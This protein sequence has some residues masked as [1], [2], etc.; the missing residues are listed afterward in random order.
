MEYKEGD[1]VLCTVERVSDTVTSVFLPDNKTKGTIISSEIAPGRIKF[2]RAYVVPNKKIVCK[3]LRVSGDNVEL[4]LRRVNAKEKKQVLEEFKQ[5]LA[6]KS[7][8]KQIF[9]EDFDEIQ[10]NILK[11]YN[12]LLEFIEV[13]KE[14]SE[15]IKKY[16][17]LKYQERVKKITE[18]KRKLVELKYEIKV[19]CLEEDGIKRIKNLFLNSDSN[20]KV[21]YLSAGKYHLKYFAEN[22]K[23]GKQDISSYLSL[24]QENAKKNN[25]ELEIKEEKH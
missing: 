17:P 20:V 24:M 3:I 19:Q 8:L 25:C 23:Q 4:S 22:F 6:V 14:N 15:L 21:S 18:K 5:R 13:I 1:L 11:D 10:K 9:L 12:E 7:A 16:I 2:M